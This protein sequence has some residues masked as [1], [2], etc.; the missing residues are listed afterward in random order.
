MDFD[1]ELLN[2]VLKL[3]NDPLEFLKGVRTLDESDRENPIKPFPWQKDYIQLYV[4]L[5]MKHLWIV[6]PKS[7]RMQMSWTNISLFTWDTIFNRGRRQAFVSKKEEDSDELVK[8]AKFIVENLDHDIIPKEIIPKHD[9]TFC[10]LKFPEL[11]SAIEGYPSG[12][13]QLRQHTFSGIFADEMAFWPDAKD[14]FSAAFP[15]LQGADGKPGGR[16]S[17]VS[18][19]APGFFR[20]IVF[21]KIDEVGTN[22]DDV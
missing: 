14:M 12:A 22:V 11:L 4:E 18:S 17:G 1:Q 5:W 21:D 15:T 3:R 13:D 6:V 8:R 2:R 19:A 10:N 7:R 9:Y 16:F 20:A